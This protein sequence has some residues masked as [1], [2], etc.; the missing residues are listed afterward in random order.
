MLALSRDVEW[1]IHGRLRC[2]R[3]LHGDGDDRHWSD[4][5]GIVHRASTIRADAYVESKFGADRDL[6]HRFRIQLCRDDVFSDFFAVRP[7]QFLGM[8]NIFWH[9]EWELHGC[10][11]RVSQLCGDSYNKCR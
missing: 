10:P 9:V 8:H 5:V 4:E 2:I 3:K 7:L 11:R 1:R 6:C